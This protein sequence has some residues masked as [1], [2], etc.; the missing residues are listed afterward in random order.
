MAKELLHDLKC[1]TPT[2]YLRYTGIWDMQ[3]LYESMA[4]WF[5]H[6]KYKLHEKVYKHKHPS[7]FGV[8]RQYIW[9]AERK[10]ED[11]VQFVID[12]YYHTYDAHDI[13]VVMP[14]G[15]KKTL[16]K[17]RLWMEFKGYV[18][19]DWEGRWEDS[20]FYRSLRSFYNKYII[21]KKLE[22]TWWDLVW[23]REIHKLYQMIKEKLKLQSM[24]YEHRYWTGVH[25]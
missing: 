18:R 8:E 21:K 11:Y 1:T 5:R 12:V 13:E 20:R 3:D 10:E 25:R 9:Q 16:T 22:G 2:A 19:Y 14:D 23:Y 15:A 6:R 24:G 17:G 4:G 7:P